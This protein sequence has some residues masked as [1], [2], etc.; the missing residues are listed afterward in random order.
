MNLTNTRI[1]RIV[2]SGAAVGVICGNLMAQGWQPKWTSDNSATQGDWEQRLLKQP[3]A[4]QQP[5]VQQAGTV[6]QQPAGPYQVAQRPS[7]DRSTTGTVVMSDGPVVTGRQR[8]GVSGGEEVIPPGTVQFD[9]VASE[10][11]FAGNGCATCGSPDGACGQC[12]SCGTAACGDCCGNG[13]EIFDG[14]CGPWSTR[15]L[16]LCR[17]RR[18]QRAARSRPEWKLR[19]ERGPQPFPAPGRSLG[20]RLPDRANFVQS[21]F[22]G[23]TDLSVP[24]VGDGN[25]NIRAAMRKQYFI[26][27]GLFHRADACCGFQYGIAYDFL[28]DI[29]LPELQPPANPQRKQL[30]HRRRLRSRLLRGL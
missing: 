24:T 20:L 4:A 12:D 1:A 6:Y 17:R 21:D 10:G 11:V 26:T 30:R 5:A 7:F 14:R 23:T 16:G 19:L 3:Q 15:P 22:S 2:L 27:A 28:H 9:P 25:L 18:L 8:A 13:W 29:Y